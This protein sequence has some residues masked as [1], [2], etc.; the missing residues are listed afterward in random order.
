VRRLRG[1][2]R[3]SADIH[4]VSDGE[5]AILLA[6]RFKF[7]VLEDG[8]H[9]Q[10]SDSGAPRRGIGLLVRATALWSGLSWSGGLRA[11]GTWLETTARHLR[12]LTFWEE[13]YGQLPEDAAALRAQNEGE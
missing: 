12:R 10:V 6:A 7:D 9:Q 4:A 13:G 11:P 3:Q 2:L 5:P 8:S 1:V